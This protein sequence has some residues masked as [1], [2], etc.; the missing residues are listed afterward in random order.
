L[1]AVVGIDA[2]WTATEPSGI[3]LV[4]A[5]GQRWSLRAIASSYQ[6]FGEPTAPI[7]PVR[8]RGSIADVGALL[9]SAERL[10]GC[11]VDIVAVDMPLSHDPIT[12]R[13]KSD[14]LV[15]SAYG[16]RYCSTHTPSST[17]PGRISDNL[18]EGFETAGYP[19]LTTEVRTPGLIEVYPHPALVELT[20]AAR[21]LPYKHGKVRN[22]WPTETAADRRMKLVEVWKSVISHLD[23]HVSGVAETMKIPNDSARGW[24]MKAFEDMLDAII[25]AWVGVT[26]LQGKALAYGDERSAIW[27]PKPGIAG[28]SIGTEV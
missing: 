13:R 7:T 25:C 26:V 9:R 23:T 11:P 19:L 22:Y 1:N 20:M 4:V 18:K 14:N 2:A 24:E 15:S 16:A 3:A 8:P 6:G 28:L 21:R 12:T 10:A 17:R 5:D 27:I